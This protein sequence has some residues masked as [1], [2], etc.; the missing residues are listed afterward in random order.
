MEKKIIKYLAFIISILIANL[1]K[2]HIDI[3]MVEHKKAY[4]PLTF[5]WMGMGIVIIVFYPLFI[6]IDKLATNF[7]DRFLKAGKAFVKYRVGVFLGAIVAILILYYFYFNLWYDR[8][9]FRTVS[10][11]ILPNLNI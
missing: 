4:S 11:S 10:R 1:I 5:T 3:S 2:T 7:T 9:F 8:D 6:F